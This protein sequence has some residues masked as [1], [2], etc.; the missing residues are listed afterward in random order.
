M[1]LGFLTHLHVGGDAADSYRIALDLFAAAE[2]MGFDSGWVAQH[3][4]LNGGGRMPSS[5]AFLA[6]AAVFGG[7][8]IE[9]AIRWLFV[10]D[11][12]LALAAFAGFWLVGHDLVAVEVTVLMINWVVL[13]AGGALLAVVFRRAAR[14]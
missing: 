6:A 2:Q 7:S 14:A 10:V 5:L 13:I 8:R 9:R 1:R 12:T 3:H 4:F 11:F